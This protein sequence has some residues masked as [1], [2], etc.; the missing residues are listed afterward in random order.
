MGLE[1]MKTKTSKGK[2][3]GE[4]REKSDLRQGRTSVDS[5]AM[6]TFL[7]AE[8]TRAFL[9]TANGRVCIYLAY[10]FTEPCMKW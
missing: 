10:T 8:G 6:S 5:E 4:I 9:E 1:A 7:G 3:E 2:R